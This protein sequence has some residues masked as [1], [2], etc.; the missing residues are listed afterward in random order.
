MSELARVLSDALMASLLNRLGKRTA[1]GHA[2]T[3]N[4]VCVFRNDHNIPAYREGERQERGELT[5]DECAHRLGVNTMT[6]ARMIK[7]QQLP[8]RQACRGAP[9]VIRETDLE[10]QSVSL[11]MRSSPPTASDEQLSL[12]FQ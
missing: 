4:R 2:W 3:R 7:R 11:A 8:A 9:W 10:L 12:E 6:I 5:L 1:H